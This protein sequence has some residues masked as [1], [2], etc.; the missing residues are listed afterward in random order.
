MLDCDLRGH[1]QGPRD[2]GGAGS[3]RMNRLARERK[4]QSRSNLPRRRA[5][6]AE[7]NDR[8]FV[9]YTVRGIGSSNCRY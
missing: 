7:I 3:I 5:D 2:H 1:F 6:K 9:K 4:S 8:Y